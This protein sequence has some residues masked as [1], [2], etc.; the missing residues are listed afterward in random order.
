ML[1]CCYVHDRDAEKFKVAFQLEKP[2]GAKLS[3]FLWK[4]KD[5]IGPE[6]AFQHCWSLFPDRDI[7]IVH[8]DMSP[9]PD[10]AENSWYD[11]L[12]HYVADLPDAGLV[13]CDL[14]FPEKTPAGT[15]AVQSG[16]G[17]FVNG[18]MDYICGRNLPYDERFKLPRMVQWATFGGIYLRREAIG[19]CRG[20][21]ERYVWAYVMDVDYSL[22]ARRRGFKIY[23]VPA[24]LIHD[25]NGTTRDFLAQP[26]FLEKVMH[27]QRIFAEKW[28][29]SELLHMTPEF[30][31]TFDLFRAALEARGEANHPSEIR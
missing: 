28:R 8:P 12:L 22:E 17:V 25:E 15:Y 21:D 6:R 9:L 3:C 29:N 20:F 14:L 4:D 30:A 1:I 19:A 10:D 13:A 7:I 2:S 11:R 23:Q 31:P 27:N 18:S 16:G 24:N 26:A 5:L